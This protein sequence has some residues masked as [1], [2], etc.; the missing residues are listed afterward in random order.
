MCG[1]PYSV[2]IWR[3]KAA[4]TLKHRHTIATP[5]KEIWALKTRLGAKNASGRDLSNMDS[6]FTLSRLKV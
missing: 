1:K 3:A 6:T 4:W 2:F 5:V